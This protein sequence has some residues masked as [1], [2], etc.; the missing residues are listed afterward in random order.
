MEEIWV[1]L[2]V[3]LSGGEHAARD[4]CIPCQPPQSCLGRMFLMRWGTWHGGAVSC[5][6]QACGS[7]Q[8]TADTP[9]PHA[10]SPGRSQCWCWPVPCEVRQPG[11]CTGT[12]SWGI[13]PLVINYP[14][15]LLTPSPPDIIQSLLKKSVFFFSL[16]HLISYTCPQ[17]NIFLWCIWK[18]KR[19]W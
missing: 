12:G 6:P 1:T 19:K 18:I 5:A 14:L 4:G 9:K 7:A 17:D 15:S 13:S 2:T 11:A 16:Y 3:E 10:S 8:G